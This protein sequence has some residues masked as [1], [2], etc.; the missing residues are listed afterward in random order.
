[1]F[2][3]LSPFCGCGMTSCCT[4]CLASCALQAFT[5]ACCSIAGCFCPRNAKTSKLAYLLIFLCSAV[6]GVVLRYHGEAALSGWVS[7]MQNV[8]SNGACWGMQAD[9]RISASVL[10]FFLFMMILTAMVPIAHNGAW[11]LKVMLYVLFLG[12]SLLIPNSFFDTYARKC[13]EWGAPCSV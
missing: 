4:S 9:Y 11:L 12:I 5:S 8:C 10:A 6:L 1:M 13:M 3:M 2:A 7:I